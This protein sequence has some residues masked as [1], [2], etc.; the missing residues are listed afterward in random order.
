MS[1]KD[2]I[3]D[4]ISVLIP[5]LALNRIP[6]LGPVSQRMLL[7]KAGGMQSLFSLSPAVLHTLLAHEQATLWLDYREGRA[8]S[9]LRITRHC[10]RR[11]TLRPHCY[12]CVVR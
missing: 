3:M 9:A 1:G 12:M 2:F 8:D 10:L 7:E 11:H 6:E 5:W 4:D